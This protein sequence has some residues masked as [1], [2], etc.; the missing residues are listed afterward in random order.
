MEVASFIQHF[1]IDMPVFLVIQARFSGLLASLF[2]F[3]R[4]WVPTRIL[5]VFSLLLSYF[6]MKIG[7]ID[8]G[9]AI[10]LAWTMLPHMAEQ[11]LLGLATGVIV[12]FFVEVFL[13]MGQFISMQAG[14][15]FVNL[16]VPRLGTITPLSQFFIIT[17]TM[18]FFELNGHLVLI[19]LIVH[20]FTHHTLTSA[21][22]NVDFLKEIL[23]FSKIM[24]NGAV[25]L[26]LSVVITLLLSNLTIG[27]MT[28]FSPQINIFS[29]GINISII[30][31][32]FACYLSYDLMVDNGNILLNDILS[33]AKQVVP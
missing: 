23:T 29:V 1:G 20:T 4:G 5:L 22:I 31:G 17:A 8:K 21:S 27:I 9:V 30:V 24:F 13:M 14:L 28:K 6:V 10:D 15:G 18:I 33:F 19:Q 32:F 12:N 26:S 11:L 7:P 2:F 3:R 25:M 16:Y